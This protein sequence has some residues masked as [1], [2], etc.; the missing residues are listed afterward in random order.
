MRH[1]FATKIIFLIFLWIFRFVRSFV[2]LLAVPVTA[3][4]DSDD[5]DGGTE[6]DVLQTVAVKSS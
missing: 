2:R 3:R 6:D 4:Y 5:N 1:F